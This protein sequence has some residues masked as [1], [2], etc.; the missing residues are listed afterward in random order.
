MDKEEL[1][2][3]LRAAR[4][5]VWRKT[6]TYVSAGLGLVIGLAWNDAIV[7]FINQLFPD[8]RK[9]VI[10]KFVYAGMITFIVGFVLYYLER[11]L[12]DKKE[13]KTKKK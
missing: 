2:K 8:P 4:R 6:L 3:R 9:T 7:T 10:A 11:S 1:A 5:G 12:E 13:E